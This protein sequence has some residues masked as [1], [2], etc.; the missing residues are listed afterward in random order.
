MRNKWHTYWVPHEAD[1]GGVEKI[2][3]NISLYACQT[4]ISRK[5]S[6]FFSAVLCTEMPTFL[7]LQAHS[8]K[9]P[10]ESKLIN[11]QNGDA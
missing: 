7:R 5:Q 11:R 4:F 8:F 9:L 3:V 6:R 10:S 2:L 1:G